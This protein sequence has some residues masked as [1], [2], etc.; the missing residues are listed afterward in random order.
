[1]A[2]KIIRVFPRKT[3]ATPDDSD[4]RFGEPSLF[5]EADKIV[6]SVTFTWDIPKAERLAEAWKQVAPVE[7]GGPAFGDPGGEFIPGRF[8]KHGYTITSRGCINKCWFCY[9]WKRSGML[10]ELEIKDGWIIQDDNLLACSDP[11]IKS[12]FEMLKRQPK[13]AI[14]SGGLEAFLLQDWHVELINDLRPIQMFFAYDTPDDYDPL[15]SAAK[16]LKECGFTR[17]HLYA[18]VLIGYP[19]DNFEKA[20]QRLMQ[21]MGLGLTPFAMLYRDDRGGYATEWRKFQRMWS[22]PAIIFSKMT[23]TPKSTPVRQQERLGRVF[24]D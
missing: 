7:I 1:M 18:Y 22:R 15:V 3:K 11:H 9:A 24:Y 20:E 17:V 8:L 19:G 6:V 4:V 21:V 2:K 16:R 14:F 13:K 5:D 23:T 12:V 10:R